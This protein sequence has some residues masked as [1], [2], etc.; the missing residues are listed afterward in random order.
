MSPKPRLIIV[1]GPNGSGKTTITEQG[2][3]H[4]WFEGCRYINPDVIAQ[5]DFAGWNDPGSVLKAAQ[6]A[7]SLRYELLEKG[8]SIAFETVFSTP[9]KLEFI[10]QAK[11]KGYFVRLF[12]ICT[13]SPVINAGRIA[14]RVLE[15]GHEVPINKIISRYQKS[16]VNAFQAKDVVDRFYLY[17]NSVDG[18]FP[19]LVARFSEG[20]IVKRY[21]QQP[22]E[23]TQDFFEQE[24]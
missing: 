2:L 10:R 8:E 9:E 4:E 19:Q 6:K 12:F 14:Q 17:D 23:W 16:I 7:T 15:G 1:A 18:N 3:A 24:T 22:P 11:Q 21:S 20:S 5:Q 13:A